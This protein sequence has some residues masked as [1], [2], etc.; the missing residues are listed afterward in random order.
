MF[1]STYFFLDIN[2]NFCL[3]CRMSCDQCT[4]DHN[5]NKLND[6]SFTFCVIHGTDYV[7]F[8]SHFIDICFTCM[9]QTFVHFMY[10]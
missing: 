5:G 10:V 4:M 8:C 7:V 1:L 3:F 9:I 2:G 6:C